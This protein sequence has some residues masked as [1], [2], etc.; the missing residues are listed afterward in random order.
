MVKMVGFMLYVFHHNKKLNKKYIG[1]WVPL[2]G[3][4]SQ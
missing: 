3:I 1:H 2:W 4:L